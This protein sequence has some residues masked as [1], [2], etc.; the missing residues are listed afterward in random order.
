MKTVPNPPPDFN[1]D[2]FGIDA[3]AAA[4]IQTSDYYDG[5]ATLSSD[6]LIQT[7]VLAPSSAPGNYGIE[8]ANLLNFVKSLYVGGTPT[9]AFAT[10]RLN[11][12]VDL[13]PGSSGAIRGFEMGMGNQPTAAYRPTLNLTVAESVPEPSTFA[14]LMIACAM[15]ALSSR[16]RQT[17]R[18]NHL[19]GYAV[20]AVSR[21]VSTKT[22]GRPLRVE[23]VDTS[24]NGG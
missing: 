7:D 10:F 5:N 24:I 1:I 3:R 12:N 23:L 21:S 14:L 15:I 2:L 8:N 11:P 20:R 9:S 4:V 18:H 17:K 13:P 16:R 6:S 22:I 19:A